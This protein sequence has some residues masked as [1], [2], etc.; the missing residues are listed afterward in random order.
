MNTLIFPVNNSG[1]LKL[2]QETAG[3]PVILSGNNGQ[4]IIPAGEMVQL[5]NLYRY[6]KRSDVSDDFINPQGRRW[7]FSGGLRPVPDLPQET[8]KAPEARKEQPLVYW[9]FLYE[10]GDGGVHILRRPLALGD[11]STAAQLDIIER[12][13]DKGGALLAAWPACQV[14]ELVD[15]DGPGPIPGQ[16]PAE[17]STAPGQASP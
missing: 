13:R 14:V 16:D 2:S 6:V 12:Y 9:F 17:S 8:L 7:K 5:C 4:T 11:D 15:I 3:S 1:L 10:D